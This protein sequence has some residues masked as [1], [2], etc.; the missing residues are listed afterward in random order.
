MDTSE[1]YV[2]M[3]EKAAEIQDKWRK[4][5]PMKHDCVFIKSWLPRQDQLQAILAG[6]D[7]P[8][9]DNNYWQLVI[10][11]LYL[12]IFSYFKAGSRIKYWG[13]F[14]SMEQIWL[15]FVMKEK[16][17]KTWNGEDWVKTEANAEV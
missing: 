2:Q 10:G 12:Q 5:Y 7:N 4:G 6:C 3:C 16:H 9:E 1:Q 15:A 14:T 8:N 13:Q 11:I 17:G